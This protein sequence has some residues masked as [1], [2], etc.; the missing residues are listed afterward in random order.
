MKVALHVN[1][2]EHQK[3][4]AGW[5]AEG[6]RRHGH[7]TFFVPFDQP[8]ECDMA[9]VWGWRQKMVEMRCRR[10]GTPLLVMERGHIQPRFEFTS[11]GF[12]G[13]QRHAE[14]PDITDPSRWNKL[15][16]HHLE[17]WKGAGE[18]ALI[19]GQV[20]GDASIGNLNIVDWGNQVTRELNDLGYEVVYR[21]HPFSIRH[22]DNF[23]PAG[24]RLSLD[25]SLESDMEHAAF[26]VVYCSTAGVEAALAGVPVVTLNDGA[27]AWPVASHVL[28]DPIVKPDRTEWM[29]RLAWTQW[30]KEEL[31]AGVAWDALKT[32]AS[33][34]H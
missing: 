1:H 9:V 19:C 31:C 2:A 10:N 27:M 26:V 13:I 20:R 25:P 30:T 32:C 16:S 3:T 12:G 6:L 29:S 34:A 4:N 14:Y 23:C 33:I 15:F 21:P 8:A 18:Y 24:A 7:E 17:P 28:T 22:S 11:C 5:M